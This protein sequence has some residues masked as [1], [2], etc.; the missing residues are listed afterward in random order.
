MSPRRPLI[1]RLPVGLLALVLGAAAVGQLRLLETGTGLEGLSTQE[2][3][4][5]VSNLTARNDELATEVIALR[6]QT[7][8]LELAAERGTSSLVGLE[9]D[10]ARVRAWAGLDPLTGRG[11]RVVVD[12]PLDGA[13]IE[14]LLNEL[15]NAGAEG[16][17]V[18]GTRIA[19]GSVVAGSAGAVRL[20]GRTLGSRIEIDAVGDPAVLTGSLTRVGGIVGQ[21]AAISPAATVTVTPV[22]AI[23]LP[24]S[25]R[26]LDPTR[27]G[28]GG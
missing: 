12:G 7:A 6:A 20:E 22:E 15:R 21:L 5:L 28:A 4:V 1:G 24:A 10:L 17:A 27:T 26:D 16:I 19:A 25:E 18:A 14:D 13:S 8:E 3:S 23:L 2:L 9:R 11:I